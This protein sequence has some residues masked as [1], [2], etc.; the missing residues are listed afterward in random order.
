M[1]LG[2]RAKDYH[3]DSRNLKANHKPKFDWVIG[4]AD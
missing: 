2:P 4:P 1:E 3:E